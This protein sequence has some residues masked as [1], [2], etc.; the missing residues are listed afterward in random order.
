MKKILATF[1]ALLLGVV[2]L[3]VNAIPAQAHQGNIKVTAKDCVDYNTMKATYTV[4]W[5]NGTPSGKLYTKLGLYDGGG[6]STSGWTFE[7]NVSGEQGS[8][9]FTMN[10]SFSG[11]NGPWV[12]FKIIFSD[13]YVVGG[14]TRVEG[15]NWNKCKPSQPDPKIVTDHEEGCDLAIP[16]TK[17]LGGEADRT[18]KQEYVWNG[19]A[20][21]LEDESKI[22]WGDWKYKAWD[23]STWFKKC[24]PDK[25]KD[26]VVPFSDKKQ[27]CTG[28]YETSWDMVTGHVWNPSTRKWD[29]TTPT[30]ENFVDWHR[31]GDVSNEYYDANCKPA[32]PEPKI[33]REHQ[34]YESCTPKPGY[35]ESWDIVTTINPVWDSEQRKWIDGTPVIT[36]ENYVKIPYTEAQYNA[37]CVTPVKVTRHFQV[38][39]YS[40]P[41][42]KLANKAAGYD[43]DGKLK[44]GEDKAHYGHSHYQTIKV[45]GLNTWTKAQ[46][47]TAI[48]KATTKSGVKN[49][50]SSSHT[51]SLKKGQKLTVAW[52]IHG[53]WRHHPQTFFAKGIA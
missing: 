34:S 51:K 45:K 44:W 13:N 23:D 24:A 41:T 15:W 16:G 29:E 12:A 11:S 50:N 49:V 9:T 27:D 47:R 31:T 20:W 25:P 14:D 19:S 21:V 52:L 38:D 48:N 32:P 8:T 28:V 6:T 37:K 1:V 42:Q 2:G 3:T 30:K 22:S 36:E 53:D 5:T 39:T 26:I 35:T 46:W 33:T 7:K 40:N 43:N 4:G 17:T 18:G 10:H